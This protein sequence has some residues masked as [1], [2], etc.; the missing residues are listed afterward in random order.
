[1][2]SGKHCSVSD[3]R[4]Y[5]FVTRQLDYRNEKTLQAFGLFVKLIAAMAGAA[6]WAAAQGLDAVTRSEIG[7]I[8]LWLPLMAGIHSILTIYVNQRSWWGFRKAEVN[9]TA[10]ASAPAP[11]PTWRA[12]IS[13]AWMVAF[14]IIV[15]G[16]ACWYLPRLIQIG[17]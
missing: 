13:E 7:A 9:L 16:L 17:S 2:V 6:V 10:S 5:E 1:M 3:E 12:F 8:L 15:S 4:L 14:I 11:D